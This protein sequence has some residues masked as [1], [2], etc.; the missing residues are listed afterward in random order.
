MGRHEDLD[1]VIQAVQ[2]RLD[3]N[4]GNHQQTVLVMQALVTARADGF[5]VPARTKSLT[6]EDDQGACGLDLNTTIWVLA[7]ERAKGK[8]LLIAGHYLVDFVMLPE[9]PQM[10]LVP[11]GHVSFF[12]VVIDINPNWVG[13]PNAYRAALGGLEVQQMKDAQAG[14]I[15]AITGP[16]GLDARTADYLRA[17][18]ALHDPRLQ[19]SK[20]RAYR[21]VLD[22]A[23]DAPLYHDLLTLYVLEFGSIHD[24]I[25]SRI[26]QHQTGWMI[27]GDVLPPVLTLDHNR[28]SVADP[29][30]ARYETRELNRPRVPTRIVG[31]MAYFHVNGRWP[32]RPVTAQQAEI[33]DLRQQNLD[34][35]IERAHAL[36][37]AVPNQPLPPVGEHG[38]AAAGIGGHEQ[39]HVAPVRV[40]RDWGRWARVAGSIVVVGT[41]YTMGRVVPFDDIYDLGLQAIELMMT[42]DGMTRGWVRLVGLIGQAWGI[43]AELYRTITNRRVKQE[44]KKPW[45]RRF[46]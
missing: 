9:W 29:H 17:E 22:R 16:L 35:E 44:I 11:N 36:A 21:R 12:G 46:W 33:E 14:I 39:Q 18:S 1:A 23:R 7:A 20:S 38:V 28:Y 32:S 6:V 13:M 26:N 5:A 45:Y 30:G 27:T 4:L 43:V 2:Q 8:P 34:L 41:A 40:G 10:P 37:R 19:I 31:D 3:A 15:A 42:W 25:R 24:A